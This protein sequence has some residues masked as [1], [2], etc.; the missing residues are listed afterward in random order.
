MGQSP[1]QKPIILIPGQHLITIRNPKFT[2]FTDSVNIVQAETTDFK[3]NLE[4]VAKK[5]GL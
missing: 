5:Q 3:I 2:A 4:Q 1:F